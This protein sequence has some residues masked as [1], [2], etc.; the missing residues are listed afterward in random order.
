[1]RGDPIATPWVES[2]SDY[3]NRNLSISIAFDNVTR[4][5]GVTTVTRDDGCLWGTLIIGDPATTTKTFAV[6]FG[7]STVSAQRLHQ[8]GLNTIEDVLALQITAAA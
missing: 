1:M 3:L 2:F 8:N 4:A 5:L 7:T 6:P